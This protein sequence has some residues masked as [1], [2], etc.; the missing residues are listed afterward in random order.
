MFCMHLRSRRFD[1]KIVNVTWEVGRCSVQCCC[2]SYHSWENGAM[3]VPER[4]CPDADVASAYWPS[5]R[6]WRAVGFLIFSCRGTYPARAASCSRQRFFYTVHFARQTLR[7]SVC[8][9]NSSMV[10]RVYDDERFTWSPLQRVSH[11]RV[12]VVCNVYFCDAGVRP[13]FFVSVLC[14]AHSCRRGMDVSVSRI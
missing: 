5:H 12:F 4:T 13:V 7:V 2:G 6:V 9:V 3:V 8:L 10:R 11:T 14:W 1:K